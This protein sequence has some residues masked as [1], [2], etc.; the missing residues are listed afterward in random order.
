LTAGDL[1][2]AVGRFRRWAIDL[3]LPLWATRGFDQSTLLFEEQLHFDLTPVT[4]AA[5]RLIVQARQ[6]AVYAQA[7]HYGWMPEGRALALTV[8]RRMIERYMAVDGHRG[9]VYSIDRMGDPVRRDRDLYSHAFA[10]YALAWLSRLE[11]DPVYRR[12]IDATLDFLDGDLAEPVHGGYWDGKP[13]PDHRRRQNPHMHLFEALMELYEVLGEQAFLDRAGAIRALALGRFIDGETALLREY[14]DERWAVPAEEAS[15]EPGHLFEWAWLL[16]R[17][18]SLAGIEAG[19]D[20][21]R[22]AAVSLRLGFDPASGRIV[23]E[24]AGDGTVRR[25]S[26]RLWPY[27]EA[28]KSLAAE[29]RRGADVAPAMVAMLDRLHAHYC[30]PQFAGGWMDQFDAWDKPLT[31]VMPASSLYHLMGALAEL[32]GE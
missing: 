29:R 12:A 5:R 3:A 14:F 2:A 11:P 23:D 20:S 31:T 6:I 18:E 10:L 24:L 28:L 16:R 13:R 9:W 30:T 21:A 1:G 17:Y 22:L 7:A 8:G 32:T 27:T 4:G 25:G 19:S 15:V 26:S